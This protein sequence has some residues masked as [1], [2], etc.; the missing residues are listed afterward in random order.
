MVEVILT[1]EEVAAG[2]T[3][4]FAEP[5]PEPSQFLMFGAGVLTLLGYRLRESLIKRA[6]W[7][8]GV[9]LAA[10]FGFVGRA[11]A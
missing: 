4:S 7:L 9:G 10:L 1:A 8:L 5:V 3:W 2:W 6:L 11:A